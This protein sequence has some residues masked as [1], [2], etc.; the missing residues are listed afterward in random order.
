V[1]DDMRRATIGGQFLDLV[2]QAR[3]DA[4]PALARE[5]A[6]AKT[7][8][9]TTVGPLL[10]GASLAGAPTRVSAVL[11]AYAE[12]LGLAFQLQDDLLDSF[13]DPDRTGKPTGQD[14][15]DGK[16]TLLLALARRR[17][18][19]T[20]AARIDELL[21]LGDSDAVTELRHLIEVTGARRYVEREV[22]TLTDR[23]SRAVDTDVLPPQVAELLSRLARAAITHSAEALRSAASGR[24]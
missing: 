19:G 23:A 14:L 20:T 4:E 13:G 7:A 6:L 2:G 17:G 3:G 18:G 12:P 8:S 10:F 24:R 16:A 21:T 15:R 5:I 9:S 11:R 22:A 1:Y